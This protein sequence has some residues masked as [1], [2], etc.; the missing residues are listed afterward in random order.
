[1]IDEL[2]RRNNKKNKR[3]REKVKLPQIVTGICSQCKVNLYGEKKLP[4]MVV[5]T[6]EGRKWRVGCPDFKPCQPWPTDFFL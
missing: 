6:K 4:L 5:D 3:D 1:M 2:K